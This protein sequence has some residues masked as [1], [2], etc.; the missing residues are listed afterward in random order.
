[1]IIGFGKSY[2]GFCL[3]TSHSRSG[4]DA[5]LKL[6]RGKAKTTLTPSRSA[7]ADGARMSFFS[8]VRLEEKFGPF[9]TFQATLGFIPNLLYAQTLLP[10]VIEAQA[11][12][13]GACVCRKAQFLES[14][15]S[16]S[17]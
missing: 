13:E 3:F 12:L 17:S 15:R 4:S 2:K 9:A 6:R 7:W 16:E 11:R 1:M 14:R 8:E 10:R 5:G